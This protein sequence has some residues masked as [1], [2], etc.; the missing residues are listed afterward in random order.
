MYSRSLVTAI[1]SRGPDWAPFP[2][3]DEKELAEWIITIPFIYGNSA[4]G[5]SHFKLMGERWL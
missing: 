4:D 2:V 1:R 5:K 3:Q